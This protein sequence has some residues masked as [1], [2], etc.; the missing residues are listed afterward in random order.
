[1]TAPILTI[2]AL[3]T[4]GPQGSKRHVGNGRM[5]ESSKKVA[6]WRAAVEAA[7]IDAA[8]PGWTPLDGPLRVEFVFSLIRGRTVRRAHHTTYPDLS[9]LIR[10][11]EDAITSAEVW[12]DDARIVA[13]HQPRKVYAGDP[14]PDALPEPGAVV[15]IWT[16]T[17]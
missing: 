2:T 17:A 1:M 4:P 16:V 12:A 15:R 8:G 10:S 5:L 14:G 3:G 6:P 7:A 11:T 9:K 13:Y